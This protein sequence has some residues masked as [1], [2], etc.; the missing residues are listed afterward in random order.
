MIFLRIR[1]TLYKLS[2]RR[3][4]TVLYILRRDELH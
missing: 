4:Y 2:P 3:Q 1:L